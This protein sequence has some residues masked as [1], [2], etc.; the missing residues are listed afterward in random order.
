[1]PSLNAEPKRDFID[2]YFITKR[3]SLPLMLKLSERKYASV[4]YSMVHLK[5]S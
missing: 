5:K 1:M 4:E 2:V 3:I